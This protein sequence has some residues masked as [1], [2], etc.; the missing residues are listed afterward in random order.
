[1]VADGAEHIGL[2]ILLGG[3]LVNHQ[4]KLSFHF[5]DGSSEIKQAKDHLGSYAKPPTLQAC[6]TKIR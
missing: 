4:Q 6:Q 3:I 2:L 5:P 1:M